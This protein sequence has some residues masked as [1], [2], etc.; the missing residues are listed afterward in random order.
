MFPSFRQKL[1]TLADEHESAV[2]KLRAC[3][4]AKK[5]AIAYAENI[6][7]DE[8]SGKSVIS[9]LERPWSWAEC[10]NCGAASKLELEICP[11]CHAV[12]ADGEELR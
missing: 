7:S 2:A 10:Y 4:R 8:Y 6:P 5:L 11:Y 3:E 9:I 12:Q 1:D